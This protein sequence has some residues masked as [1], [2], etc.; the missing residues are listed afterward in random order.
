M[1]TLRPGPVGGLV[2]SAVVREENPRP[3]CSGCLGARGDHERGPYVCVGGGLTWGPSG[4]GGRG[5]PLGPRVSQ[6]RA[7]LEHERAGAAATRGSPRSAAVN[8]ALD[9]ERKS[10]R[11]LISTET[12]GGRDRRRDGLIATEPAASLTIK[13]SAFFHLQSISSTCSARPP[14]PRGWRGAGE[15]GGRHARPPL[16]RE[17]R[18]GKPSVKPR[19]PFANEPPVCPGI[20]Q[21]SGPRIEPIGN[22]NNNNSSNNNRARGRQ[23]WK[24]DRTHHPARAL[25]GSRTGDRRPPG[26]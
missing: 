14:S 8:N 13:G 18:R 19:G 16:S 26:S 21:V 4:G 10:P 22:N 6:G 3:A 25:T 17:G 20:P 12:R 1:G 9:P 23:L 5:R 2:P 24:T 11:P 7:P 15:A